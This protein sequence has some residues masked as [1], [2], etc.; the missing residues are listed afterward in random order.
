MD[1]K[2]NIWVNRGTDCVTIKFEEEKYTPINIFLDCLSND[3]I[4][5]IIYHLAAGIGWGEQYFGI[6]TYNDLDETDF[7]DGD[8][9]PRGYLKIGGVYTGDCII[10]EKKFCQ[11]LLEGISKLKGSK[12]DIP[13]IEH[14]YKVHLAEIQK[15]VSYYSH[16][17]VDFNMIKDSVNIIKNLPI[18]WLEAISI[19]SLRLEKRIQEL[20]DSFQNLIEDEIQE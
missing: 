4:P 10:E 1:S 14:N 2:Y 18:N 19:G 6:T 3:K 9:F 5:E 20:E 12:I 7:R 16:L 11:I 17:S 15:R 8:D 13:K